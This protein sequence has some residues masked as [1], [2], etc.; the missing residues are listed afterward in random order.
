MKID[1][2]TL[3]APNQDAAPNAGGRRQF[4][5]RTPL[6]ARVGELVVRP[7]RPRP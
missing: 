5:I 2:M 3:E 1:D 4:A 6:T 7:L